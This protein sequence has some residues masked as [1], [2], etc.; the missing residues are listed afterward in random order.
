MSTAPPRR[1][2]VL[3]FPANA[4]DKSLGPAAITTDPLTAAARRS[5]TGEPAGHP[6]HA[7]TVPVACAAPQG[8]AE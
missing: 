7:D 4:D 5:T 1:R 6:L 8:R 3:A 2:S